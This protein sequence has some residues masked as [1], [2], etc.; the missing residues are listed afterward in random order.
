[1]KS[2][3]LK[4]AFV[5]TMPDTLEDGVLYVSMQYAM[6]IHRCACGCGREVVAPLA[7][8][9]WIMTFDGVNVS[10]EP[11]IGNWS[12]PCR[13][14][15]WVRRGQILWAGTMS[16]K[17]IGEG[18]RRDAVL[19]SADAESLVA[20][21]SDVHVRQIEAAEVGP[22]AE[23]ARGWKQIAGGYWKRWFKR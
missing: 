7:P 5:E 9:S 11:S 8:A 17:E 4:P 6:T 18:R 20:A 23:T 10:L 12:F 2:D 1:M 15:Y 21:A 3:R 19:R 14:H 22:E 13:S 16:R